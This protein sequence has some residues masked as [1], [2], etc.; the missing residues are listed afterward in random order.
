MLFHTFLY[1]YSMIDNGRLKAIARIALRY[2]F[3]GLL[4]TA[5][6]AIT[7][8]VVYKLIT[9]VDGLLPIFTYIDEHG[10]KQVQNY[11][12]GILLLFG[13]IIL[14][15]F[16][17][18]FFLRSRVYNIFDNWMEKTP[19]IKLLYGTTKDF[20]S[21]VAGNKK[22]FNKPVLA[23]IEND[24]VYRVGFITETDLNRF[25]LQTH[26]AVYL[27]ASYSI[28]GYVYLVPMHRVKPLDNVSAA[29]AMKFAISGGVSDVDDD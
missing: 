5:P 27:P 22:K 11:G 7:I 23:A 16:L 15:G 28:S 8:Y 3:Q 13:M 18:S 26:V 4:I 29:D 25:G 10:N 14:I 9:S 21:A 20:F 2:F 17:S 12:L 1:F 19:G 24:E 6:I